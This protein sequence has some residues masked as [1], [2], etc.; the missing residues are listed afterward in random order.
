[1]A[2]RLDRREFLRQGAIATLSLG[3]LSLPSAPVRAAEPAPERF[4]TLGATGLRISDISFG[5]GGTDDPDLIR[6]AF[7]RGVR[8]F[9][10]AEGYPMGRGGTAERAIGEA[11][12]GKRDQVVLT[13]KVVAKA[14]FRA[15]RIMRRLEGSLR[16]LQT[17]HVDIYLNHAVNDLDRLQNPEWFEFVERAKQQGKIRF[18]GMS[19]HAGRLLACLD[20]AIER[21]L[22]DVILVAYNFGEDPAFYEKLTRSFDFVANQQGL[23]ERI[24]KAHGKGIGVLTMKTLMGA[25]LND[26][27]PY[28]REGAT[29]SQAA[30]RWVLSNPDVDGL[31][32]SM[33]SRERIDEYLVAS[34]QAQRRQQDASL[35]RQ[36]LARNG[37]RYCRPSCSACESACPA[38]VPVGEVLRARMYARDYDRLPMARATYATLGAGASA[39]LGCSGPCLA[40]C[41]HGL[42]VPDLTRATHELL[43]G[44]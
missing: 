37:A 14:G 39:C 33:D 25:R 29:F 36:Y 13:S 22:V 21:E 11:L 42:A 20:V 6:Y 40:A 34:G 4:R 32:I 18:S 8:S 9:D 3:A 31:V 28:E 7:D 12:K 43:A 44:G 2:D 38:D 27:R 1:M 41:P 24:A 16:R 23:A 5:S 15:E 26:M 35:L 10:T 17:D 19:G 30:F